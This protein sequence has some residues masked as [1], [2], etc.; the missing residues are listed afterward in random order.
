MKEYEFKILIKSPTH[1]GSGKEGLT[2]DAEIVHDDLGFPYIPGKR[3]KGLLYESALEMAEIF[4]YVEGTKIQDVEKFSVEKVLD[5]FGQ[6]TGSDSKIRVDNFYLENYSELRD[7]IINI[8]TMFPGIFTLE[9][10][11][12]KYTTIRSQTA[13]DVETG[14]A[15]EGSLRKIR[16][17]N[18]DIKFS[19]T[20]TYLGNDETEKKICENILN[21]ACLNLRRMGQQRNRGFGKVKVSFENMKITVVKSCGETKD[22]KNNY[23]RKQAA[24]KNSKAKK[25][26]NKRH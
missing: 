8:R 23:A 11:I 17:L 6:H 25:G 20:V 26:K 10:V 9:A 3:V 13:I 21:M 4:S 24:M 1:I 5:L 22:M 7:D 15:K 14:T 2:L 16:L 18:E 19:G 12:Q